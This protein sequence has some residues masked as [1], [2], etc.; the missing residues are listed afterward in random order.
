M[1]R[2]ATSTSRR[3][4][5]PCWLSEPSRGRGGGRHYHT[6]STDSHSPCGHTE[7][8]C[9]ETM[10]ESRSYPD[11]TLPPPCGQHWGQGERRDTTGEDSV[12]TPASEQTLSQPKVITTLDQLALRNGLG[13]RGQAD[14]TH[15]HDLSTPPGYTQRPWG[16]RVGIGGAKSQG[17]GKANGWFQ[18]EHIRRVGVGEIHREGG[19]G[20]G[21]ISR[22][23]P[24]PDDT[25]PWSPVILAA[26]MKCCL[27][28]KG[29]L[30]VVLGP[31]GT[32]THGCPE[33]SNP[34]AMWT[35]AEGTREK[36]QGQDLRTS[37]SLL[38]DSFSIPIKAGEW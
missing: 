21:R 19:G 25:S 7:G 35:P 20:Y 1:S 28:C 30:R 16:W 36:D 38:Q 14:L 12:L 18:G 23:T 26:D 29:L 6:W 4:Q 8:T 34:L 24:V 11:P 33:D 15:P 10:L 22:L 37:S 13:R 32:N 3:L 31:T 2:A 17:P 9:W 5:T 27:W